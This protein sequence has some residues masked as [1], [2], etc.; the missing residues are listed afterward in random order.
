MSAPFTVPAASD[1]AGE[2]VLE[3][4]GLA[5]WHRSEDRSREGKGLEVVNTRELEEVVL[6]RKFPLRIYVTEKGN[7]AKA[8]TELYKVSQQALFASRDQMI[9]RLRGEKAESEA[10][11][12]ELQKRFGQE[13][14]DRFAAE[15]LLRSKIDEQE[16]QLPEFAMKLAKKN[17]DNASELYIQAYES[18]R[19]GKIEE[20]IAILNRNKWSYKPAGSKPSR[21]LLPLNKRKR[22]YCSTEKNKTSK[23]I[24]QLIESYDL[25]A[26]ALALEFRYAEVAT[27]YRAIIGIHLENELPKKDLAGW[28]DKLGEVLLDNG[29]YPPALEAFEQA[30][31]IREEVL[32]ATHPSLAT[33]YNNI[34]GTY[35]DMGRMGQ[36]RSRSLGGHHPDLAK[37]LGDQ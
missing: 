16:K 31:T 30:L 9:A 2:F 8:Q 7:L 24:Q 13:L 34:G 4:V 21:Q 18:L 36:Q 15:D 17:L 12:A 22:C 29:T 37:S 19:Q 3:F 6:G 35:S 32:D 25:K 1:V 33:S 5:S 23:L 10:A 27:Q 11:V 26:D 20:T 28:Y 14:K